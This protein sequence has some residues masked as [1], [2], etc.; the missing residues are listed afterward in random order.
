MAVRGREHASHGKAN[1]NLAEGEREGQCQH[2]TQIM[3][4]PGLHQKVVLL[5]WYSF[6]HKRLHGH[7]A[8]VQTVVRYQCGRPVNGSL[9]FVDEHMCQMQKHAVADQQ[10]ICKH[11]SV[12]ILFAEYI[13]IDSG[14][15][16]CALLNSSGNGID[17]ALGKTISVVRTRPQVA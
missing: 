11:P 12:C 16:T 5:L 10:G 3:S 7:A 1:A 4:D 14:M 15:S 13:G 9:M 8:I 6:A 17:P 2:L